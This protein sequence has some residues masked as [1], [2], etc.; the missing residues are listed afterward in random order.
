MNR[1]LSAS[2][3]TVLARLSACFGLAPAS[4]LSPA[5][6]LALV[7]A[8]GLMSVRPA[9][10]EM[11]GGDFEMVSHLAGPGLLSET[12]VSGDTWTISMADR[13][14]GSIESEYP[15]SGDS[16]SKLMPALWGYSLYKWE[17]TNEITPD[18]VAHEVVVQA[19][20]VA[21]DFEF[22]INMDPMSEAVRVDPLV[23]Q[24]ANSRLSATAGPLARVLPNGIAELNIQLESGAFADS[25]LAY[26]AILNM[27]YDD[28]DNDGFVDGVFPPVRVKTLALYMLDESRGAWV[29]VPRSTV[30]TLNHRVSAVLPHLSVYALISTQ[31]EDVT[32]AYA[33]P[34]P[35]APNSGD[36]SNGTLDKGITFANIPSVGTIKIYTI[37]GRLVRSMTIPPALFPA[38]LKWDGKNEAGQDVVSGVYLWRVESGASV[39]TGKLMIIR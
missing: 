11:S 23:V 27:A 8:F 33:F 9:N 24:A 28:A 30:D 36:P 4:A 12:E 31:D 19:K 5:S 38:Q 32:L 14:V 10:A 6:A 26:S 17:Q 18:C 25:S 21:E 29:K 34:V 35:W 39:K 15:L 3:D 2:F 22:Y 16:C 37:T 1:G 20:S 13:G 7:L